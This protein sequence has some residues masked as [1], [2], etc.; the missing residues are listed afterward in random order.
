MERSPTIYDIIPPRFGLK[1]KDLLLT[2][3]STAKFIWRGRLGLRL[4]LVF[5]GFDLSYLLKVTLG[6][7]RTPISRLQ[8][9]QVANKEVFGLALLPRA[10]F[11]PTF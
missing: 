7:L 3:K 11:V 9:V 10:Q 6:L 4:G 8:Q 5:L 2:L 1:V